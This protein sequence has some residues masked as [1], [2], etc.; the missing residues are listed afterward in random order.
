LVGAHAGLGLE[1]ALGKSLALDF[2]GRYIGYLN[3]SPMDAS[4]PGAWTTS[5]GLVAHF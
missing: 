4:S 1:L 2:E 5:A 3:K